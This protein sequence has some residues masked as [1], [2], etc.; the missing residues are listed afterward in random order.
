MPTPPVPFTWHAMSLRTRRCAGTPEDLIST[1][2]GKGESLKVVLGS[3]NPAVVERLWSIPGV[4]FIAKAGRNAVKLF[5]NNP[6]EKM[7]L[8]VDSLNHMKIPFDE[9][10][11]V[12]ADFFDYFQVKPWKTD[13]TGGENE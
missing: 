10:S 5:M 3:M 12:E 13:K 6:D 4:R 9:V 1:L 7:L 11:L 2:P 8:V